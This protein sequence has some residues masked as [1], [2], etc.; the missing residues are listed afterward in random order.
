MRGEWVNSTL[1][2]RRNERSGTNDLCWDEIWWLLALS[3]A[4]LVWLTG[5]ISVCCSKRWLTKD[6]ASSLIAFSF[7]NNSSGNDILLSFAN[8]RKSK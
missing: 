2:D 6:D 4:W 1:A 5:L 7:V 3:W 8:C